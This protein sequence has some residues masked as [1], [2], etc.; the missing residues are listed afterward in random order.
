VVKAPPISRR[1][2]LG[3]AAVVAVGLAAVLAATLVVSGRPAA[4]RAPEYLSTASSSFAA[5]AA[6]WFPSWVVL[7]A[8]YARTTFGFEVAERLQPATPTYL[9]RV[10]LEA[11]FE[12]YGR[13]LWMQDWMSA[14][15]SNDLDGMSSA[16]V[17]LRE[18]ATW[19]ATV[20]TAS[21][22]VAGLKA[23]AR[24]AAELEL[25]PVSRDFAMSCPALP[26]TATN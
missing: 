7:P 19:P 4:T 16:A 18:S 13:C 8:G 22:S 11:D 25:G 9:S 2:A 12:R 6:N 24:S 21:N 26:P 1:L 20:A 17:V 3:A 5:Q 10:R 15:V 23:M 14:E